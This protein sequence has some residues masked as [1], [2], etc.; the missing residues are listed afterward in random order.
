MP[1]MTVAENIFLGREPLTR[2]GFIDDRALWP[3]N[4]RAARRAGHR[5]RSRRAR[6]RPHHRPAAD[7]RDRARRV[8][9]GADPHHGRA[10]VG[11]VRARSGAALRDR[12][13]PQG[14]R[15]RDH[16]HHAQDRRSLQN[17][18]RGDRHARRAGR[19]VV[20][21]EPARSRSAHHDDG[22]PRADAAVSERQRAHRSRAALGEGAV[23]R[24]H[25]LGC[26]VRR[27]GGGD[28][29]RRRARRIEAHGARG[30]DLRRAAR[31]V[32]RNLHR[33]RSRRHRF[34]RGRDRSRD[35]VP[36]RGSKD[37]RAVPAALRAREH[38]GGG[39]RR[40]VRRQ[41]LREAGEAARRMPRDGRR[42]C[43]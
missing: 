30:N 2:F 17:R 19:R 39:A 38:G 27:A 12:R 15:Q 10:D 18:G 29:G 37:Q 4:G 6:Q 43:A 13:R 31:D 26:V 14:P 28:S 20:A 41:R 42:A 11:A 16:L 35:G 34:A 32:R 24:R 21:R 22:R 23:A 3:A 9:R 36:H 5:Y 33:W 25:V 40:R 7:D 1:S 8:V